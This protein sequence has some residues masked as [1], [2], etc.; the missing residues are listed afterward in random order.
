MKVNI[1]SY[2]DV[3]R[4]IL[5]KFALK[6]KEHLEAMNIETTISSSAN[7]SADINHHI[8]YANYNGLPSSVDTLMITHVDDLDKF[9]HL[10]KVLENSEMGICMSSDTLNK[11]VQMGISRR[12]L[13][14]VNPA[15]DGVIKIRKKCIG[16]T[17]RVQEDGRKRENFLTNLSNDISPDLFSFIIMGDN[18]DNQIANLK[19]K[20]FD[21][22]YYNSFDYN[23]YTTLFSKMDYYLYMGQDEGQM[24]FVDA[25]A[26]GVPTI[27]TPQGYHLD[28]N[29]ITYPF[30]T[31]G[32]LLKI[33]QKIEIDHKKYSS[34]V[35]N[36]NWRDYAKKHLEIWEY[37][38]EKKQSQYSKIKPT[39]K[40]DGLKSVVEFSDRKLKKINRVKLYYDLL[41]TSINRRIKLRKNEK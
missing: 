11:M 36:W 30:D 23:I 15:H 25:V 29:S 17:C 3:N 22:T 12:K 9:R 37:I 14:F 10:K 18:W 35:S 16:I 33:L 1:I 27:V 5:G 20:K 28:T 6:L 2:E 24:G 41:T 26:A 8:I 4:W 40:N 34:T 39:Y 13:C 38:L 19:E 31:Y 21:V 32:E 7:P